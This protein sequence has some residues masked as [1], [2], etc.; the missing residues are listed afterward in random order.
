MGFRTGGRG[1][2]NDRERTI[3]KYIAPIK[4]YVISKNTKRC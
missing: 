1:K 3:S 4:E 2:K